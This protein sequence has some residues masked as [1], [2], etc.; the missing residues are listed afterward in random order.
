MRPLQ[1]LETGTDLDWKCRDLEKW[2]N[3]AGPVSER[4]RNRF[5]PPHAHGF[6]EDSGVLQAATGTSSRHRQLWI[7]SG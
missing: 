2:C 3:R 5:A 4:Y 6:L 1:H 7:H